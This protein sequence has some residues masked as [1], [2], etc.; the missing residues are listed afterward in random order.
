MTSIKSIANVIMTDKPSIPSVI[1]TTPPI[2]EPAPSA[3]PRA[4]PKP[5]RKTPPKPD[6]I[7]LIR[8]FIPTKTM[9]NNRTIRTIPGARTFASGIEPVMTPPATV[10][11]VISPVFVLT[12]NPLS[13]KVEAIILYAAIGLIP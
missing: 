6:V 9:P 4:D 1:A 13:L 10:G 7:I 5:P 8:D 11:V 12:T 2:N 3:E